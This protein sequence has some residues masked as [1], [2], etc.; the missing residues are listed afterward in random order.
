MYD[1]ESSPATISC[2]W[3]ISL[4][5]DVIA[6]KIAEDRQAALDQFSQIANDLKD[7]G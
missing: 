1:G 6:Q 5:T 2:Q 7:G 4:E 3:P